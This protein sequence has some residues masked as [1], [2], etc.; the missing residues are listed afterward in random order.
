MDEINRTRSCK[1][2][3]CH[4]MCYSCDAV[5]CGMGGAVKVTYMCSGCRCALD[6]K[7]SSRRNHIKLVVQVAFIVAGC[8]YVT[9]V[10]ALQHV[11]GFWPVSALTLM[12]TIETLHP[13]VKQ[14]V[15]EMCERE[16]QKMR[17]ID[18]TTVELWKL[19]VTC[20]DGTWMTSSPPKATAESRKKEKLL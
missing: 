7:T 11:L 1:T 17:R 16:K 3:G 19:A 2:A 10:K 6:F 13:I 9:Y 20:A 12:R 4:G 18:L 8:M 15:D 5:T 14:M